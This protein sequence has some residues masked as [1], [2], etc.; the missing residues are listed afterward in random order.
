MSISP[1]SPIDSSILHSR[2]MSASTTPVIVTR[3]ASPT[4]PNYSSDSNESFTTAF[5]MLLYNV[6]Y[7]AY[8]QSV[9]IPLSQAGD[10]L[11]NLW[12]VCCSNDLGRSANVV[13]LFADPIQGLTLLLQALTRN[14]SNSPP[15]NPVSLSPRLPAVVAG[16][17]CEPYPTSP[18]KTLQEARET[19]GEHNRRGRRLG[20]YE[21]H[22]ILIRFL[23]R[24]VLY[25]HSIAS[26]LVCIV[27]DSCSYTH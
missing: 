24:S 3:P 13:R 10:V 14:D 4:G 15:A 7:L 11:S 12:A 21:R 25:P 20:P 2:M 27:E 18:N 16:N 23:I 5:A 1:E 6:C 9:D 22:R 19:Q 17:N 8:T 26:G